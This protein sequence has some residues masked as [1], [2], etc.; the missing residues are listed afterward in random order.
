M[1]LVSWS[2][3]KKYNI[4]AIFDKF[5]CSLVIFRQIKEYYFV[6]TIKWNPLDPQVRRADLENMETLLNSELGTLENYQ[7]RKAIKL[8]NSK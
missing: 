5:P 7:K 4:K 1:K 6:Y 8:P 3:T 2:Y